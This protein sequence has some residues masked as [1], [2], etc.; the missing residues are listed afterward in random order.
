MQHVDVTRICLV[1]IGSLANQILNHKEVAE[2]AGEVHSCEA[3]VAPA[4]GVYPF[5]E[6]LSIELKVVSWVIL[7]LATVSIFE[8][9]LT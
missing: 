5:F 8:H 9:M 2:E 7:K 6:E 4:L 3:V 1:W